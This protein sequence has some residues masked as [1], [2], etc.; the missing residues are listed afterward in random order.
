MHKHSA[1]LLRRC[2]RAH[3]TKRPCDRFV[4][5]EAPRWTDDSLSN[6][7][8]DSFACCT[9]LVITTAEIPDPASRIRFPSLPSSKETSFRVESHFENDLLF[10]PA[11]THPLHLAQSKAAQEISRCLDAETWDLFFDMFALLLLTKIA[12]CTA[13][14]VKTRYSCRAFVPFVGCRR[15]E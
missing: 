3:R 11:P 9:E 7:M 8:S 2:A 10:G 5:A 6:E 14:P 13:C 1:L 4:A 15:S 12:I